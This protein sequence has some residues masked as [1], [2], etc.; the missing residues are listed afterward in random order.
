MKFCPKCGAQLSDDS[1]F[2]AT[3]GTKIEAQSG[4]QQQYAQP[5][6]QQ[7]YSQPGQYQYAQPNP[8]QQY[9]NYAYA[10]APQPEQPK[11]KSKKGLIIAIVAVVVLAAIGIGIWLIVG[12]NS[13]EANNPEAVVKNAMEALIDG[14]VE[15]ASKYF[16]S[17]DGYT[18][19]YY[20]ELI[21]EFDKVEVT[22]IE[23]EDVSKEELSYLNSMITMF[24][25][26]KVSD[27]KIVNVN[28]KTTYDGY[29]QNEVLPFVVVE[30]D[31][32]W[33]IYGID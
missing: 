4:F 12:K 28:V 5:N 21:A 2:C 9:G 30:Q 25:G 11:K 17:S 10:P 27:A 33:K 31:G 15:K 22:G 3:C 23:V 26:K 20:A 6:P 1:I 14:D 8:Q 7:Q 18:V 16:A 13:K 32:K 19:E 29:T 24:G